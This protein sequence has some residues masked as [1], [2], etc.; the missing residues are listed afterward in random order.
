MIPFR[1]Q[2]QRGSFHLN[3]IFLYLLS[4]SSYFLTFSLSLSFPSLMQV[5]WYNFGLKDPLEGRDSLL[6]LCDDRRFVPRLSPPPAW[7]DWATFKAQ[8]EKL[9]HTKVA[10]IFGDFF[11][12][13]WKTQLSCKI[14]FWEMF[15][16]FLYSNIWS[17]WSPPTSTS[18][19]WNSVAA[20]F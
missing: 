2:I 14:C 19:Y 11:G 15:G 16:P 1:F 17:H 18:S 20:S 5:L 13:H 4:S 10:Q 6:S 8:G 3:G 12:L 9:S 7:P